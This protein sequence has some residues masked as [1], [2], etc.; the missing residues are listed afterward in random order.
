M[1]NAD[2]LLKKMRTEAAPTAVGSIEVAYSRLIISRSLRVLLVAALI[3][4]FSYAF[5]VVFHDM[6]AGKHWLV[7]AIPVAIGGFVLSLLPV[8]EHWEYKPWQSKARQYEK[9][10]ITR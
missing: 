3:V 10:Q 6:H 4:F 5:M 9:H 7:T 1:S 2:D 8:S